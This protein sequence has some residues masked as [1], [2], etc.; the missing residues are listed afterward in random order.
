[1]ERKM[2]RIGHTPSEHVPD[3]ELVFVV[4]MR[5]H[6]PY[7]RVVVGNYIWTRRWSRSFIDAELPSRLLAG[8]VDDVAN[9][10]GGMR[11]CFTR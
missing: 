10:I 2:A 8:S 1:M 5:M 3:G 6:A 11:K 7:Q 4:E 9:L